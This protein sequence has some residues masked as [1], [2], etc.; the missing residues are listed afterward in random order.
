VSADDFQN[1]FNS[2]AVAVK[3]NNARQMTRR[4]KVSGVP[5]V[6]VNGKYSTGA[7]LAGSNQGVFEVVDYLVEQ[8]HAAAPAAPSGVVVN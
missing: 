7:K 8:E 1:T 2:F 3:M 5:T 6:I 4:Y